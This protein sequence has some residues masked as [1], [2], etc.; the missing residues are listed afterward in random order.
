MQQ[1]LGLFDGQPIADPHAEA[2]STLH[3][4]NSGGK[5][6]TQQARVGGHV[7]FANHADLIRKPADGGQAYVDGGRSEVALFQ[8]ESIPIVLLSLRFPP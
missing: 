5:F 7:P 8:E 3:A 6:R 4:P 1:F 2:L